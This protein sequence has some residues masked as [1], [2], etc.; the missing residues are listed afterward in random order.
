MKMS[1]GSQ[2]NECVEKLM[3]QRYEDAI[4]SASVA[5]SATVRLECPT[6]GDKDACRRFLDANLNII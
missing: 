3:K 2:V 5:M 4:I 6:G 1:I